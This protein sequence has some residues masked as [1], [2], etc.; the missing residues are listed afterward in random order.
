MP[1]VGNLKTLHIFLIKKDEV[2]LNKTKNA[3]ITLLF[4]CS[5]IFRHLP[6]K[7]KKIFI[8]TNIFVCCFVFIVSS[9]SMISYKKGVLHVT[10]ESLLLETHVQH[11]K[12]A[13]FFIIGIF[14]FP[15]HW[16]SATAGG[17]YVPKGIPAW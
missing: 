2:D 8:D 5:S 4:A 13:N 9:V 6:V 11:T 7:N 17:P 12:F 3:C 14:V 15:N 10:D 1:Y 16:V